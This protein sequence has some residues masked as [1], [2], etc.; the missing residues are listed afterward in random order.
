MTFTGF[1]VIE[2]KDRVRIH[3]GTTEYDVIAVS[4]AGRDVC[5][6]EVGS[7]MTGGTWVDIRTVA[8]TSKQAA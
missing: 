4:R 7:R 1:P 6:R 3:G 8:L 2:P 5:L